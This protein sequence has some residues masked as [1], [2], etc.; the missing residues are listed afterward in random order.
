MLLTAARKRTLPEVQVGHS[1]RFDAPIR[2]QKAHEILRADTRNPHDH[3]RGVE[4]VSVVERRFILKLAMAAC[5]RHEAVWAGRH[6]SSPL[7]RAAFPARIPGG[8]ANPLG[9]RKVDWGHSFQANPF[10]VPSATS[11]QISC[12]PSGLMP[13]HTLLNRQCLGERAY[14]LGG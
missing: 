4:G 1:R 11:L 3:A 10:L 13:W 7:A 2:I 5:R 9:G 14:R 12:S 8:P 6:L